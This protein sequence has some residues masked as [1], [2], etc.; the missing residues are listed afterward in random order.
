MKWIK[1]GR[2]FN[3]ASCPGWGSHA[4]VPTVLARDDVLRIYCA[5]RPHANTSHPGYID[6]DAADPRKI[7]SIRQPPLLELGGRGSFDEFGIMPGHVVDT[8]D[9]VWLFYTGWS[10][11]TTVTYL[12]SIGLAVSRDG[13]TTFRKAFEGPI[14]DR[15]KYEPFMTMSPFILRE[16]EW[17][18]MWYASGVG[19][20]PTEGKYEPRYVIKY[21]FS[22]NGVDWHQP[23]VTCIEPKTELESN[24]RPTVIKMAGVYHMWFAYR[25]AEDYRGGKNSYRIGYATSQNLLKWERDDAAA[26]ISASAEGWDSQIITYPYV[27]RVRD[28]DLMFYNGN[29]FGATGFGYAT[30]AWSADDDAER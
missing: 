2:I 9:E 8:G 13:G 22:V 12:L 18:H 7:I 4:Q 21:A 16:N 10:R 29:G 15:T 25:G 20:H 30:A 19:F 17:W 23:N 27:V 26:G 24:T 28:R 5:T 3:P 14:L 6:V 1:Q 11:G